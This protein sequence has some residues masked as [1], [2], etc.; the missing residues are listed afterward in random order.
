MTFQMANDT[1]TAV[2]EDL[3]R[4]EEAAR[5]SQLEQQRLDVFQ[6]VRDDKELFQMFK[7][8]IQ[9]RIDNTKT[10]IDEMV[11]RDDPEEGEFL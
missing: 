11:E 7:S 1:F 2:N 9:E 6:T 4:Q 5:F 8:E 10:Q 3:R